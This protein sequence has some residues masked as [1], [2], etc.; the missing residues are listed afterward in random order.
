[1]LETSGALWRTKDQHRAGADIRG[2]VILR[3]IQPSC[4]SMAI[5]EKSRFGQTC[6]SR[7]QRDF[8]RGC[9]S[10]THCHLPNI[11]ATTTL[12]DRYRTL[13]SVAVRSSSS[14]TP[15][16]V[17]TIFSPPSTTSRTPRLVIMRPTTPFPV[18]GKV[19]SFRTLLSPCLLV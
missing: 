9:N 13:A 17:S 18:S 16:A 2:T 5:R 10:S 3:Q 6:R 7:G 14:V 11:E 12:A 19:H 4:Q 8:S 15:S 1:M